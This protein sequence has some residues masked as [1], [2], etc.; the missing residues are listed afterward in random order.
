MTAPPDGQPAAD[1]PPVP[2]HPA[3]PERPAAPEHPAA[4][5]RP[6][7]IRR[8]RAAGCVFAEDEADLLISSAGS[9]GELAAMVE[10]RVAGLPLEQVLGWVEFAGLRLAVAPDV[11]VPR[12][13]T[14]LL[15]RR[16]VELTDAGATVVDLCCGCGAIAAAVAARLR[17]ARLV[18]ADIHPAAVACARTNLTPYG[19][20][21][22]RGDLF[23]ALPVDLL[24]AVDL[25]VANVPYVPTT[26]VALLPPEARLHEPRQS[27]DG[28]P[29]GLDVLRRVAERGVDWLA[30]GGHLVVETSEGQRAEALRILTVAGLD[31]TAVQDDDL[32][33][34]VVAGRNR[35]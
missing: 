10:R 25:L 22:C 2:E 19:A 20:Q 14:E 3:A 8:L 31:A 9:T 33:A 15:V 21:V 7:V 28:G 29:D 17:P 26:A 30:P 1:R 18:A 24:G 13:R 32:G 12:R 16:A 11:F 34:T 4:P 6:A 27:L 5:D 23:E 35:G